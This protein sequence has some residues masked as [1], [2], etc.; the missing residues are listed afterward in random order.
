MTSLAS[1]LVMPGRPS[2]SGI[3]TPPGVASLAQAADAARRVGDFPAEA[4]D[5][6]RG[7]GL[8]AAVLPTEH[9]GC[10]LTGLPLL[11]LLRQVGRASLPLGR[12]YEGHLNALL[13]IADYGNA[14]QLAQTA[15]D[16][17]DNRLYGVWNTEGR[18]PLRLMADGDGWRLEGAKTF[19]TGAQHVTRPLLPADGPGGRQ[20]VLFRGESPE[21]RVAEQ[22]DSW[23]PLGMESTLSVTLEFTGSRVS[24]ADLIGAPGDYYRQPLFSVGA[25]RF[26]AVQ[27]GGA[28]ALLSEVRRYLRKLGRAQDDVQTLRFAQVWNQLQG[29]SLSLTEGE[30]LERAHAAG[31]V[32]EARLLA[33]VDAVR[34][35]TED[36]CLALL[37]AAERAVG[38]RGLTQPEPFAWLIRDLRM[39][40]RQ[41]A[42]DAARLRL[43]QWVMGQA[44]ADSGLEETP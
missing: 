39:Y 13:L 27:L 35:A 29:A 11:H 18:D 42:P 2:L 37:E 33:Q 30:R 8:W 19:A 7:E 15:Q 22:P 9:G 44:F 4:L 14:A 10:G 17:A 28:D 32:G 21:S 40:L 24:D 31:Q 16:A 36:A 1:P 23:Q 25:L 26:C 38:A 12:I 3:L 34:L 41:P 20:L 43:G 5:I 6:L